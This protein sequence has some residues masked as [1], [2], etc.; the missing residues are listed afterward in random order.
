MQVVLK[1]ARVQATT[2]PTMKAK[3]VAALVPAM[4]VK[5][6]AITP[7][8]KVDVTKKKRRVKLPKL[9]M[10]VDRHGLP[11]VIFRNPLMQGYICYAEFT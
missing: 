6:V 2:V 1:G 7:A 11:M 3:V 9:K 8:I 5:V 4:K 10:S